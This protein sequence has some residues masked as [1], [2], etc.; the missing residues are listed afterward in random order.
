MNRASQFKIMALI[1]VLS[2]S[3][4]CG[5]SYHSPSVKSE[6]DGAPV[7]IV[8]LSA[9]SAV[10]ANASPYTPRQLPAAFFAAAG[11]GGGTVGA[12][13]LPSVPEVPSK[14]RV[15][16]ETYPLPD[17]TPEAYR[18][19]MGDVLLLA[20]RNDRSTV[21]Q[22]SGLLAAQNRRQGYTVRD[23]GS[24]AIPDIGTISMAGLTLKEAEDQLFETLMRNQIDPSFSLEVSAFN[25]QKI[26]VGGAVRTAT[27]VPVT[28]RP[29]TLG[30]ALTAAGGLMV[31]DAEFATIRIYR[32]GTLYQIPV[33]TYKQT[34]AH[35]SKF[36]R[37]GDAIYVDTTYD[38]DRAL[39]F[40]R[41]QIS[42]ISLRSDARGAALAALQTEINIR[43][44]A[45]NEQRSLFE[46]RQALG[47]APR[48]YVYMT[49]EV[50][51]QSRF[52]LP[53]GQQATLADVLFGQGGFDTTTGNPREIYVLRGQENSDRITAYHLNAGNAAALV[54]ATGF[55]MRPNDVVFV[56]EQPITK[57]SRA[58]QQIFP[59]L[60][61]EART[62]I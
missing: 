43:R 27:L 58:L 55:E 60:L 57:W 37:S 21:E 34:P 20:T 40:Y 26:T 59:A 52:A 3:G 8:S 47:A 54:T 11:S 4:A 7:D 12:G 6:L 25:S 28:L 9:K 61:A 49:G 56:E 19:G 17:I 30:E 23:D 50:N 48:D 31:K 32:N 1:S 51:S 38:L 44:A 53:Y 46:G 45:L 10:Q 22:L 41:A 39:E 35:A 5:V 16:L 13:A 24:I 18:I 42:V 14:A 2:F 36:L 62:A 29:L 15:S 33:Q